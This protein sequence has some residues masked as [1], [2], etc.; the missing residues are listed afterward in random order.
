MSASNGFPVM[1]SRSSLPGPITIPWSLAEK[2]Y[3]TYTAKHGSRSSLEDFARRGGFG[4]D[5]LDYFVPGWRDEV[6]EITSLRSQLAEAKIKIDQLEHSRG[7]ARDR[8]RDEVIALERRLA[9]TAIR[10]AAEALIA[11]NARI[12]QLEQLILVILDQV[13]YTSGACD[14]TEMVG[15]CIPKEIIDRAHAILSATLVEGSQNG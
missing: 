5:E 3:S 2:A 12:R 11:E 6:S 7:L 10:S 8:L 1:Y 9:E 14:P 4:A 15:A 13:D